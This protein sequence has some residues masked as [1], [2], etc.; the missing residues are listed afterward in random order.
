MVSC[1]FCIC[2]CTSCCICTCCICTHLMFETHNCI[3]SS[4]YCLHIY[5]WSLSLSL[6]FHLHST[7]QLLDLC[8]VMPPQWFRPSQSRSCRSTPNC[9]RDVETTILRR[10]HRPE[11]RRHAEAHA[12]FFGCF[13][14][15]AWRC[16]LGIFW[17][18]MVK[19][20]PNHCLKMEYSENGWGIYMIFGFR[21]WRDWNLTRVHR[22]HQHDP[23]G[24][25]IFKW[26]INPVATTQLSTQ[27]IH[28][29]PWSSAPATSI[30]QLCGI[31]LV[32]DPFPLC[33]LEF[34]E[35]LKKS[36][37]GVG[38]Q[39]FNWYGDVIQLT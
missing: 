29:H 1:T 3:Q 38:Q 33:I 30:H 10:P 39:S 2:T 34:P 26:R 17:K 21:S 32:A 18:V 16:G 37:D 15:N 7:L 12:A 31:Y 9:P 28:G 24:P 22:V 27:V 19:T 23:V 8:E 35:H 25:V 11:M 13:R 4:N 6:P 20:Y 5:N 36:P 14:S